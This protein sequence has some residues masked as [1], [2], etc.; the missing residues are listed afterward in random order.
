MCSIR[1][2]QLLHNN[3][4]VFLG[5]PLSGKG[6]QGTLLAKYL[7]R[8]Y[9]ST[10]DLFRNEVASNSALGQQIKVYMAAG[11]LIPNELTTSF[12]TSKFHEPIYQKG[13]IVDGYP[14]NPSHLNILEDILLNLDR[15]IFV[16]I[17]LD[18]PKCELDE[19]RKRRGRADDKADTGEHRYVVFQQETLPLVDLLESRNLL[20]RITCTNQSP[21]DIH[22]EILSRLIAFEQQKLNYLNPCQWLE[23]NL[24]MTNDADRAKVI[25][26][27][28]QR[29]L[30]ENEKQ[31]RRTGI[32]RRVVYLRTGNLRKYQEHVQIFEKFYGIEVIRIPPTFIDSSDDSNIDLLFREKIPNLV[33]LAL[34]TERSN[35]YRSGTN[36]LSSLRHGVRAV[37]QAILT[38]VWFDTTTSEKMQANF[39]HSISGR[40]DL[41]RRHLSV[42]IDPAVFGWDDIFVVDA[43]GMSYQKLME[44]GIKHSARDMVI[45][46]F[47]KQRIHYKALLSLKFD[48]PSKAKRPIDFSLD[49]A[50]H[51]AVN[52][53][54]NNPRV[55]DYGFLNLITHVLNKGIFFRSASNRRQVN[56][57]SP[58]L[59]GGLPL[60]AKDDAIHQDTFMAHD[61]GH[62]AIPDLVFVGTNTILHRRAYIAWRMIS[63]ATT[64]A[65][66]D[67]LLIDALAKSGVQYDFNKRRIYPLF[68][69]LNIDL[70]DSNHRIDNLKRLIQ[71]NYRY[72]L[73]GDDSI[74]VRMLPQ[75]ENTPSLVE[76]KKKFAPFFVEDYRWT[77][78]N[79]ENMVAR[80]EEL[81]RWWSDVEP[82]RTLEHAEHIESIDSFIAQVR[83]THAD[84]LNG[85]INDFIDA[86]FDVVY[87]KKVRPVLNVQ[88]PILLDAP[89][90]LYKAFTKWITAQ[91]AITSKFHFLSES[92]RVRQEIISYMLNLS[93]GCMTMDDVNTIR[94]IFERYL[95]CLVGKSLITLDDEITYAELYPLFDPFYVNYDKASTQYEELTAISTRIFSLEDY[96]IKQLA[97]ITKHLGR[98]LT[99][100]ETLYTSTMLEMIEAGD[101]QILDGIFV[102]HPGVMILSQSPLIHPLGMVTFLL[103]GISI[104]TSLEFVA[105]HEAKVARLTSSK[106]NAMNIPLLRVQGEDT[107]QQRLF[108]SSTIA[109][110]TRFELLN[111]PRRRWGGHG[112][113]IF[114][115]MHPACKVSAICYTMTLAD[116][117]KLFIGRM[118]QSGNEQEVIHVAERM[119]TL[120]H[121]L[122]P[123]LIQS[124]DYYKTCRNKAKYMSKTSTLSS[125]SDDT[126]CDS[127]TLIAK[128]RLTEAANQLLTKLNIPLND[129]C[130]RLAEFRSRITYLSFPKS[131]PK[132]DDENTYL[133]KIIH[134]HGH[135]SVLDAC[136]VVLKLP[137]HCIKPNDNTNS[138]WKSF[139]FEY[140]AHGILLFATLKQIHQALL[141]FSLMDENNQDLIFL[142][143]LIQ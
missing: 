113:E 143:T 2:Q 131:S 71:A 4:I 62:F 138:I 43:S 80:S 70:M 49:V 47:I 40:I 37:N 93:D 17:Y 104:E 35:L 21:D 68:C 118:T 31:G 119:A 129:E 87:E 65:L 110:R 44:A 27:F 73:R 122:Y 39:S 94:S 33:Q 85:D 100:N 13:M 98:P 12:L 10:G 121:A 132:K 41:S 54:Y 23:V 92:A 83:E 46:A 52:S 34:I 66:A 101:G 90:R 134:Q 67:M 61:F 75:G 6:T 103:S 74:Y 142:K 64:M 22:Q 120:L 51:I 76:F 127:V 11:E 53:T 28:R 136:Q 86:V 42:G 96:R 24:A 15:E 89:K 1:I 111:E 69:D 25:N 59:N 8:P 141:T 32:T 91:L 114:N 48:P 18:V 79:Y 9:V 19:R 30:D 117:H 20:I 128:T 56:Y 140:M 60:T 135:L 109:A 130:Q 112:N 99:S 77:E 108:L 115:I 57:W 29:A 116:F 97:Q 14:R 45:S 137:E 26:E 72:C 106:T 50:D 124:V 126:V 5:A 63:E 3:I 7:E 55:I 139:T 78:H 102:T 82:L 123:T 81:A 38:A 88:A 95:R 125:L 36:E 84:A 105:H 107:S 16:A 58:G 133:D